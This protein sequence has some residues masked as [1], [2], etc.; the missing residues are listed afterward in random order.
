[1][2]GRMTV[3]NMSIEMGASGGLIAPDEIT[4]NYLKITEF[5]PKG[6]DFEKALEY[7]KTLKSD[8]GAVFDKEISYSGMQKLNQ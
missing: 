7:W 1:M 4:F 2:E 8:P 5:A 3:C 6:K